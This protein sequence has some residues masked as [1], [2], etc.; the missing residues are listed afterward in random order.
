M[1]KFLLMLILSACFIAMGA[2]VFAVDNPPKSGDT[3]TAVTDTVISAAAEVVA[4]PLP[5]P[6]T[7]NSSTVYWILFSI[8]V[9][10]ELLVRLIPTVKD[11]SILSWVMK[12]IYAII[13][14]FKRDAN[15]RK[16]RF[17]IT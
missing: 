5:I 16:G 4:T 10:Y 14:N 12:L 7:E 3:I 1:K 15:N 17:T 6:P 8:I 11:I 9:I 2:A 13:P